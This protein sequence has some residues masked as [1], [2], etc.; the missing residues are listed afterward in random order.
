MIGRSANEA[1][2]KQ[3]EPLCAALS[4]ITAT[5]LTQ[6]GREK[7]SVGVRYPVA[8]NDMAPVPLTAQVPL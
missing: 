4:C 6:Q 7:L 5:R 1:L 8:L 3:I 2:R